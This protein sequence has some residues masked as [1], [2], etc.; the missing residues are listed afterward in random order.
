MALMQ[1]LRQAWT[2]H[3]EGRLAEAERLYREVLALAPSHTDALHFLGLLE[4]QRGNTAAGLALIERALAAAPGNTGALY[5][6][7]NILADSGRLAEALSD[8]DRVVSIRPDHISAWH[9]RGVILSQLGRHADAVTSY[10]RVLRQNPNHADALFHRGNALHDMGRD[11]E[12]LASY[13]RALA[14]QPNHA[15]ALFGRGN[16]LAA[17]QRLD[18][19][20][21]SYDRAALS[22]PDNISLLNNRGH[23]LGLAGRHDEALKNLDR[24][25]ALDPS[26]PEMFNNRGNVHAHLKRFEDAAKSYSSALAL[27]ADYPQALSGL[28]YALTELKRHDEAIAAFEKL[29]ELK[30]DYP[31]APGMLIYA[32][33]AACD[34]RGLDTVAAKAIRDIREGKRVATPIALFSVSDSP[35]DHAMC[36]R[37]IMADKHPGAASPLWRGEPYR[38]PRIRVAYISAD[39]NAHAVATLMAGV[40]EQHDRTRFET[41]AISHGRDDGSA[42]RTRLI[43]AFDRF[44]DVRNKSDLEIATLLRELETD[45]AVDLTGLTG[46][47]RPGILKFRPA[48]IQ[49]QHLGFAGTMGVEYYDYILADHTVIPEDARVHFREKVVYLPD[50][51]LPNDSRRAMPG[52]RPTRA[53]CG[54]PETGFVFASFNNSY[55]FSPAMFDIW[56]RLLHAI[57][58][59]V[60]W[61][62]DANVA[63][64]RNLRREAESRG[65]DAQ[66]IVF[67][68][69]A[70]AEEDHL[71]R[72]ARADLFLD[73]L[74]YNAH[75]T[76]ADALWAGLPVLTCAGQAFPG[77][78]AASLLHAAGLPELIVPSLA[79]YEMRAIGLARDHAELA[80][81]KDKLARRRDT[82]PL[83]D[84]ARF[85]RHLE[86]AYAMM[87]ERQRHGLRPESFA[88]PSRPS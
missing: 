72:L 19:A 20:I 75:T 87:L 16:A 38:H 36:S 65:V 86:T 9:N 60:L 5:N 40:F 47:G 33:A 69:Y 62:P 31:Y 13:E 7:A 39:F 34:W 10:D 17:L 35:A 1:K 63:A 71:A 6:R 28:A 23:A 4:T 46:S 76:A 2:W 48:G 11:D 64:C 30:P 54:L 61:L 49:V 12:A 82:A 3:Q 68:A 43:R 32:K 80:A 70:P 67:A 79:A 58:G 21:A 56:M 25:I 44:I 42:L 52:R 84:T 24:A 83:F 55:K 74:P 78:V 27:R 88:V 85:T 29:L 26:R 50:T 51:Y 8:L 81:I 15:G 57:E 14:V 66:R 37:I 45:I 53:A 41:I 18:E 22:A 77:R 73:T 59:S